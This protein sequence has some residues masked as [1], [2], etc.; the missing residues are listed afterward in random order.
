MVNAHSGLLNKTI[1]IKGI[2][3]AL[4]VLYV[5]TLFVMVD[6]PTLN[7]IS[8][9]V[10]VLYAFFTIL[11]V[12]QRNRLSLGNCVLLVGSF[13]LICVLSIFW[14]SDKT[15]PYQNHLRYLNYLFYFY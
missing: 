7:A 11:Y 1:S 12:I 5:I 14:A 10:F 4:F 13:L 2:A 15:V 6:N 3:K 8:E 9:I